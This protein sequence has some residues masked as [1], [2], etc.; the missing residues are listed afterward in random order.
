MESKK[1]K[2]N[3]RAS[4]YSQWHRTLGSGCYAVDVDWVEWR[5]G[6]GVVALICATGRLNDHNHIMNS[7]KFI[8]NRTEVE[9]KVCLEISESLEVPAYF[10]IH[11]TDL[12]LFH[13]HSIKN[14]N[15]YQV[16][17]KEEYTEFIK[18]L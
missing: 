14:W 3:E 13:V 12:S 16:M 17:N 15:N 6:R 18:N 1:E 10:V 2:T 8:L 5:A 9:R 11:T 4:D 7:K